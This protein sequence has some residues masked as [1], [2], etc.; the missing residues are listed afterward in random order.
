M[1]DV[2]QISA[3]G[4]STGASKQHGRGD[5]RAKLLAAAQELFV[6]KGFHATRPQDISRAAGVGHGTFYLH[7][8]D[9]Q[10]CFL[11][12]AEQAAEAL[13][14]YVE[15]RLPADGTPYDAMRETIRLTYEFSQAHPG[16][17]AAALT[18]M[19]VIDG[20]DGGSILM[21]RWGIQWAERLAEWKSAGL[22][23]AHV[24]T[25]YVGY[26][27]PGMIR[28]AGERAAVD[29]ADKVQVL[30]ALMAF[31]AAGLGLSKEH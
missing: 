25:D 28:Q 5:T 30:D 19:S 7:F 13:E 17:L 20:G 14:T 29:E 31:L 26:A 4:I 3:D 2:T 27:I 6:A 21:G 10:A 23:G 18:D 15:T 16:I 8:K 12:F 9:K 11:A 1:N 24:D 22:I